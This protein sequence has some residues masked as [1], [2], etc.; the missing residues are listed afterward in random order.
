MTTHF[1]RQ[2]LETLYPDPVTEAGGRLVLWTRRQGSRTSRSY[3]VESL[4]R[5]VEL[6]GSLRAE[7]HVY[8][9]VALQD[10][11]RALE[12]AR[13]KHP[14]VTL[15]GVR[16]REGTAVA[17]P[18]IFADLDVAGEGH[19]SKTL[20][21]DRDAALA[22]LDAV[23]CRPSIIV[24]TGGGFHV[25]W[26]LKELWI[27]DSDAERRAA[28]Q[29]LL[30]LQTALRNEARR[31][32]WS[33]DHTAN[34]AQLLRLPG[35]FNHKTMKKSLVVAE[36]LHPD[37][38]YT[39]SNFDAL[40]GST[41]HPHPSPLPQ[42]ERGKEGERALGKRCEEPEEVDGPADFARVR[43]GCPWIFHCDQDRDNLPEPEWY[44][45]L[46]IAG[47]CTGPGGGSGSELAHDLSRGHSGYEPQK[48]DDKLGHAMR[49]TGPRGC[50]HVAF[51]LGQFDEYCDRCV[52]FGRIAGPIS[53]GRPDVPH[54][55]EPP[56]QIPH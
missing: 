13:C 51:V 42:G 38:R 20:P 21:P 52:H 41:P 11:D 22:L 12:I 15:R 17:L 6:A 27:L 54:P 19:R 14:R 25:Y 43:R 45:M 31:H 39:V 36:E 10:A 40:P 32:G 1:T 24:R 7:K 48:T 47:R 30:R 28:K 35:T 55:A 46:S 8:F 44:A 16:G 3:W 53:L 23:P 34:P 37:R 2:F 56:P 33:I 29:L 49:D 26:L 5:A 18:A 4:D 50:H 9:G